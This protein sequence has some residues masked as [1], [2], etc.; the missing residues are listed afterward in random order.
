MTDQ[1]RTAVVA[2]VPSEWQA[3][4]IA[5]VLRDEGIDAEVAGALTAQFRAEAPGMV[6]VIVPEAQ[7]ERAL[8]V[9]RARQHE[10]SEID[11]SKV[12]VGEVEE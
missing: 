9:F 7:A 1:T 12:D 3:N 8:A 11:W 4:I 2:R 6:R 5:D 10:A